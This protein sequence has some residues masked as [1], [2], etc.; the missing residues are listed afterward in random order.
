MR[1]RFAAAALGLA[2]IS[3]PEL[4]GAQS[5]DRLNPMIPLHEKGS[6]VFGIAHPGIGGRGGGGRRGGGANAAVA[7][8]ATGAATTQQAA[9]APSL[10]DI[11]KQTVAYRQADYLF[12]STGGDAFLNYVKEITAA[13]GS[14]RTHPFGAKIPPWPNNANAVTAMHRQLNSGHVAVMMQYVESAQ[15]VQEVIK[16][17]RFASAGGT[18]PDSGY[19]AAA[20]FWGL[21]PQQYK[22]KADVWP[23]NPNGELLVTVI[24][25]SRVGLDKVREIA[26]EPG[27]SVIWVGF[28][29]LGQVF[30]GD[31]EGREAAAQKVL[32]AC[33][34]F[35]K[36]CGFPT[37]N[38][39]EVEQ[40]FKEGWSVFL[41]QR[42]GDAAFGGI[43]AGRKLGGR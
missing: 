16:S 6:P 32:A 12:T 19:D 39:A 30:S 21:T 5:G 14:V 38:A 34:E 10:P 7:A 36:P 2:L 18:R 3:S 1:V 43:E 29:T 26:A 28:G 8:A 27:V 41:F 23:L 4:L 33:K 24:I 9:P 25:E 22:Q 15:E 17:M 40:R 11:A 37:N 31:P 13:G 20:A 42:W 35:R